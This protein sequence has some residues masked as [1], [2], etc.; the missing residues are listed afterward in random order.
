MLTS[1]NDNVKVSFVPASF[2]KCTL[3]PSNVLRRHIYIN[4]YIQY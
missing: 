2:V 3:T 4:I 1:I